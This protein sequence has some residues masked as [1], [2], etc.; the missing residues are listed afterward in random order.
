MVTLLL[1]RLGY[2]SDLL[3]ARGVSVWYGR[4]RAKLT[5]RTAVSSSIFACRL[6]NMLGS[7]SPADGFAIVCLAYGPRS[8][9]RVMDTL[10]PYAIDVC[11]TQLRR[12][13]PHRHI[14]SQAIRRRTA[15]QPHPHDLTNNP[16]LAHSPK[17]SLFPHRGL[18]LVGPSRPATSVSPDKPSGVGYRFLCDPGHPFPFP[19]RPKKANHS[20]WL[21]A[22]YVPARHDG[23]SSAA[24]L[25]CRRTSGPL[26]EVAL[27]A[28]G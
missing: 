2:V 9:L 6:S 18:L 10:N 28:V 24:L 15:A 25:C 3:E 17:K 8:T 22:Q 11:R 19:P 26:P 5:S 13:F 27:H 4:G 23:G 20:K 21:L 12:N 7:M 1:P 16:A 14:A